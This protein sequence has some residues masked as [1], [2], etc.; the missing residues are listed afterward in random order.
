MSDEIPA[1]GR[2]SLRL[3]LKDVAMQR[4]GMLTL[5]DYTA[6][7]TSMASVRIETDMPHEG[8]ANKI[9]LCGD[10]YMVVVAG[11]HARQ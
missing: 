10:N 5:K 6:P 7:L 2:L 8:L 4:D 3:N 11:S 9:G 1:T